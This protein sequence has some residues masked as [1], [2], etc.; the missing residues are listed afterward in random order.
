VAEDDSRDE[1]H[2]YH[3]AGEREPHPMTRSSW[4]CLWRDPATMLGSVLCAVVGGLIVW[5]LVTVLP[6]LIAHIDVSVSW[7]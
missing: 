5:L 2:D 6:Y 3:G 1:E 7:H 4:V